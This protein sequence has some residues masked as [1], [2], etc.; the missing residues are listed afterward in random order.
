MPRKTHTLEPELASD[1]P[2]SMRPR[3]DAAE[4]R[5]A[6]SGAVGAGLAS[7]RPRPDAA[8][9]RDRAERQ[10]R[11]IYAS[12]RPRPDAAENAGMDDLA[13]AFGELQ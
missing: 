1:R 6:V 12:M 5:H 13:G 9:N 3:P 2:A 10:A 4:N 11:G 8:E 7:M